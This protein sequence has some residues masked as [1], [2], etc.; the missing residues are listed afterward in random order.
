MAINDYLIRSITIT[1]LMRFTTSPQAA[2]LSVEA[3][4]VRP[5]SPREVA[6]GDALPDALL[7]VEPKVRAGDG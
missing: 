6:A 2:L 3:I 4:A 5:L 7:A 1:D